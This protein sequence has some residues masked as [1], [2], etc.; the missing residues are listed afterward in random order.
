MAGK[1]EPK[2]PVDLDPPK[3]DPISVDYLSKCN[4]Q[5]LLY[6]PPNELYNAKLTHFV[7]KGSTEGYPTYVAIKVR[8]PLPSPTAAAF[9]TLQGT[10]FDVTG[11]DSYG[12]EGGYK[13]KSPST[14]H[15]PLIHIVANAPPTVFAG[16]DASRAL[17]KTSLK[18]EDVRADWDDLP[19]NEKK[20]LDDWFTFFSKRYNVVG[21]VEG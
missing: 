5:H 16:K 9:T 17:G 1:F 15:R 19:D 8:P 20:V 3:D 7:C 13:S 18:E 11:N 12:P 10:V 2:K 4:G 21:R 6:P 14:F